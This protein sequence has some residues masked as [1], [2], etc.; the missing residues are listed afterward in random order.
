MVSRWI[1]VTVLPALLFAMSNAQEQPTWIDVSKIPVPQWHY[2]PEYVFDNPVYPEK[3]QHV[4]PGM[5]ASFTTTDVLYMRRE[6]PLAGIEQH[7][8]EFTGWR[9]ERLNAQVLVWSADSLEQIRYTVSDLQATGGGRIG[10][11]NM[12]V[13]MVRYVVSNMP[14]GAGDFSCDVSNASAFLMPDRL[15]AFDRFDLPGRT[16]RP[17]WVS[18]EVPAGCAPGLYK[19]TV[20]LRDT[21]EK[22]SLALHVRIQKLVLPRPGDWKFRLDLWQNPWIIA[23]YYHV[24]PWSDEHILLLKQHLRLYADA[25]GKYITTYAEHS[26]WSDNSY[27]IEGT[28]IDWIK[29][30]NG[31]WKFRYD[32]FDR[33]VETA[34]SCGI[35]GAITVY[36]PV[37]W[38]NRF[39]Y[40]DEKTGNYVYEEWPPD[41]EPYRAFWMTFLDDLKAHLERKGWFNKTYLGINENLLEHTLAA[42][43]VI[44]DHS[45]DWKITYAGNW[46]P[47]LSPILNDY[48]LVK[49]SEP[50][51]KDLF[52][53][54]ARGQTTT[55]YI[56]C[57]PASPN[58]F[59]FSPPVEGA[60][61]GWYAAARRYD[62]LL[63]WAYDAWPADPVRDARHTQ[64]PAGDCFLVY[65]GGNSGIRFEKLREGIVACE[66]IGILRKLA[67]SSGSEKVNSGMQ[68]FERHLQGLI[69]KPAY[70][71][72]DYD[73][74]KL[75]EALDKG[76]AMLNKLSDGLS[77]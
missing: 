66:K 77:Q 44:K 70:D 30:A 65:P 40:L 75:G 61:L 71:K 45:P 6:V 9:G 29:T 2:Q 49:F 23:W 74:V 14:Y 38:G 25:G 55:F 73:P 24:E 41:S 1:S 10:R 13:S 51:D 33:Y 22:V 57:T 35:T 36:T 60:Y 17:L 12:K 37:P 39:R 11:D 19:G 58:N 18:I 28:M 26:P 27:M 52:E 50:P 48:S 53:R 15:E 68:E 63:R 59:V 16:V 4:S 42:A 76:R 47:E 54:T 8:Q 5:H 7:T 64:W 20:E 34:I 21:R 67:E 72:A 43:R 31:T 32:I 46:H 56:C 69:G 62:G 3:W